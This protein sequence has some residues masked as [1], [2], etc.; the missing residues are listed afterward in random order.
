M[1]IIIWVAL[2]ALGLLAVWGDACFSR[3]KRREAKAE[4]DAA[5]AA[6]EQA[7]IEADA[8]ARAEAMRRHPSN[9][10]G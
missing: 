3:D 1:D 5:K 10:K 8:A 4:R 6:L 7:R 9:Y 2:G